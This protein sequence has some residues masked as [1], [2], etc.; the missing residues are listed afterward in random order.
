MNPLWQSAILS[1]LR[2]GLTLLAG[3][4][5]HKGVWTAPEASTYV[6]AA[7]LGLLTL[8]WSQRNVWMTRVRFLVALM[9]PHGSTESEVV[10]TIKSGA[11]TPSVLTPPDTVPGVPIVSKP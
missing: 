8:A 11:V 7:A 6:E 3:G 10:A 2:W 5:V 4:L 9:L 1:I